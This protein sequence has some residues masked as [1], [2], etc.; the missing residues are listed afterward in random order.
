M[1]GR[2][3]SR[4][5]RTARRSMLARRADAQRARETTPTSRRCRAAR[6]IQRFLLSTFGLISPGKG[7]ETVIE[8]LPAIVERHPEVLYLIAGR[9][10][11]EVAHREGERVPPDARA[12]G[13]RSRPRGPRRVRRPL[14]VDRRAGRP[15]RRDRCLRHALRSREQIASGALTFAIA[16]G[17]AVGLDAVLVRGGHARARAPA[18]SSRSTTQSLWPMPSATTSSEPER[19]RGGAGRGRPDRRD[20]SPG[21]RL[22]RRRQRSCAKPSSCA[23]PPAAARS[24]VEPRA[25]RPC[26]PII[27]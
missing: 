4:R 19:A 2:Q 8:A 10:H 14:P 9:T 22:P 3:G 6:G 5:A 23:A 17:C 1:P 12:G 20:S 18:R 27:C 15:A 24:G 25:R 7:I 16:A 11:P 13:A 21:L 26:G